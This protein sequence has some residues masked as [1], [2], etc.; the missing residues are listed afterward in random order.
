MYL[1]IRK[2]SG[3]TDRD[4]VVRRVEEGLV[5]QIREFP[6]FVAYYAVEFDD[7]DLGSVG[8]FDTKENADSA[9]E[10]GVGWV[11]ENLAEF[12]P[13]SPTIHNGEVLIHEAAKS[14]GKTA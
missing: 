13:N 14:L 5:P 9:T 6:G 11:M 2:F 4:E 8:V 10:K 7:G 3:A 12:M 1:S